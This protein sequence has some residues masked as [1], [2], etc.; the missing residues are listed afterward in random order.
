MQSSVAESRQEH[1]SLV[2]QLKSQSRSYEPAV[3]LKELSA[4][5][6]Q[7]DEASEQ[8]LARFMEGD[9]NV[10]EF[11]KKYR[12]LRTLFHTRQSKAEHLQSQIGR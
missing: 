5:V 10:S 9:E 2:S 6:T 7:A 12:D 8:A 3:L 4:L 11:V 1:Q